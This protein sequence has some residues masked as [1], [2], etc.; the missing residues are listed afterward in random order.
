MWLV[1]S[2]LLLEENEGIGNTDK[3]TKRVQMLKFTVPVT[4]DI[5][6]GKYCSKKFRPSFKKEI[7]DYFQKTA[8]FLRHEGRSKRS[9]CF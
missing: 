3:S 4:E 7:L 8:C 2:V 1:C 5:P 6:G 9:L